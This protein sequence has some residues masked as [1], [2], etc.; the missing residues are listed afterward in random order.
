[1]K[2]YLGFLA[3]LLAAS[4]VNAAITQGNFRTESDLLKYSSGALVYEALNVNVEVGDELTNSDFI[5]NPSSWSGGVVNMDLDATTN[6]LTLKSQDTLD[7]NTFDAWITDLV[8]NAGEVITGLSLLSG[9]LT[10]LSLL[11]N[12][13]FTGNSIHINYTDDNIFN[14]TGTDAQFQIM[15]SNVSAVPIPAAAFLFAPA[16]LGFMGLRRKAKNTVA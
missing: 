10:D 6:I 16:L 11:A 3:L 4:Q 9:N 14:F 7:F 1:M 8:F 12:L 2:K 5:Q 15:T 13:S